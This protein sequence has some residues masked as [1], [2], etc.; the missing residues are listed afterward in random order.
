MPLRVFQD[1][2]GQE[3]RVWFVMP[4]GS[5]GML[6]ESFRDGWL[7]FE[8]MNGRNR[9]RLA[10]ADVPPAWD[11]LPDEGLDALR[12]AAEPAQRSATLGQA[13]LETKQRDERTSGPKTAVG[14]GEETA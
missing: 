10:I 9:R 5:A 6:G 12:Q 13:S 7:C 2:D 1:H 14:E 4:A 3:W 11:E 8:R